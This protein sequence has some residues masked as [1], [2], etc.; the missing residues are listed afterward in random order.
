MTC[1]VKNT[2]AFALPFSLS[3]RVPIFHAVTFVL[4]QPA[5]EGVEVRAA[6]QL[7]AGV[8]VASG[9]AVTC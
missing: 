9:F 4:V 6:V 1:N 2:F 3:V 8:A 5:V 7:Q